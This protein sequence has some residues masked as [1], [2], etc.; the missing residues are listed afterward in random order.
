MQREHGWIARMSG[1]GSACFGV[2]AESQP[3]EPLA[4]TIREA[5]GDTCFLATARIGAA[6]V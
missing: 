4:A 2:L 5:W 6:R 3:I 1:S